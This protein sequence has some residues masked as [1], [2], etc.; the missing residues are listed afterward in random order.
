MP[1]RPRGDGD[2]ESLEDVDDDEFEKIL[3][4]STCWRVEPSD[5][6]W[7]QNLKL[8]LKFQLN[9]LDNKTEE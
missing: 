4:E 7:R 6:G 2:D 1:R 3:G 8:Y 5:C 9:I